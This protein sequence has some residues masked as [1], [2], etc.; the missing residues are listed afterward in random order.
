MFL[1]AEDRQAAM[2]LT[3]ALRK[4]IVQSNEYLEVDQTT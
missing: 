1:D 2:D 3:V 4:L